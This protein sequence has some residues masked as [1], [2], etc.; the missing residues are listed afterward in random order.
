MQGLDASARLTMTVQAP[1]DKATRVSVILPVYNA[2]DFLPECLRSIVE[3]S[4]D[5]EIE[6]LL[7]DDCSTDDSAQICKNFTASYPKLFRLIANTENRGVSATR[8][9]GLDNANGDYFMFVDADDVLA[10]SAL[11]NLYAAAIK[12]DADIVKGNN[13]ILDGNGEKDARYN[14]ACESM[15]T[16]DEVLTALYIHE[17]VRGHPWGKFFN[18]ARLGHLRF[19]VGVRF[20][21]DLYYCGQVFSEAKSL[22]LIATQVYRYRHRDTSSTSRKF[23]TGS[24]LDWLNSVE[25][26][27]AFARN[28][29]QANAHKSLQLRTLAQIARECRG[30]DAAEAASVL[31]V[32]EQKCEQWNIRLSELLRVKLPARDLARYAKLQRALNKVRS[33]LAKSL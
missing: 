9:I 27:G 20:G 11:Q 33:N 32:I 23:I 17:K 30:I 19:P 18:R 15:I 5:H 16:G 8:N 13:T 3:Q 14:V 10:A 28:S 25:N 7:I 29:K 24:Y 6:T 26:I 21:E 31:R 4:F 12:H 22:L 2:A 1:A